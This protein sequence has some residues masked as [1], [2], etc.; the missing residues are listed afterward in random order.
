MAHF[1]PSGYKFYRTLRV[2][3]Y[4]LYRSRYTVT[5][6]DGCLE[7]WRSVTIQGVSEPENCHG[8]GLILRADARV[9]VQESLQ[10]CLGSSN[11]SKKCDKH[12]DPTVRVMRSWL[13]IFLVYNGLG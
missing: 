9:R 4:K 12:I 6:L 11:K 5:L 7:H 13:F 1:L 8:A 3:R 10:N 2:S